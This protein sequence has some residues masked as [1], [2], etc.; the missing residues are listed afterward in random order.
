MLSPATRFM[1]GARS[2]STLFLLD[3]L[4]TRSAALHHRRQAAPGILPPSRDIVE[5][6]LPLIARDV[7][8]HQRQPLLALPVRR[9]VSRL[10]HVTATSEPYRATVFQPLCVRSF[11]SRTRSG[12]MSSATRSIESRSGSDR[13]HPNDDAR[14]VFLPPGRVDRFAHSRGHTPIDKP[15]QIVA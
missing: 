9:A 10:W 13:H 8:L 15:L 7:A 11:S 2:R 14:A 6:L 1:T 4:R 3:N 5:Q 12:V